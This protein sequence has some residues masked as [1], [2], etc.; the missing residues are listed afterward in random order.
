[1]AARSALRWQSKA[2]L[3][4]PG[5]TSSLE[6]QIAS[7]SLL[8]C[9][10]PPAPGGAS[11][12]KSGRWRGGQECPS[13]QGRLER[14]GPFL[15]TLAENIVHIYVTVQKHSKEGNLG[16]LCILLGHVLHSFPFTS[17][18]KPADLIDPAGPGRCSRAAGEHRAAETFPARGA[19]GR[20]RGFGVVSAR[21]WNRRKKLLP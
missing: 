16:C 13:S 17:L 8:P 3:N 9:G 21:L 15:Q 20:N 19:T 6:L 10:K 4:R 12:P 14:P 2:C 1:M 7:R 11:S 18:P 5:G